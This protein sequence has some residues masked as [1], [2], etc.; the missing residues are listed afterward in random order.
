MA[1]KNIFD[2][3]DAQKAKIE[4]HLQQIVKSAFLA[5]AEYSK[6]LAENSVNKIDDVI[7]PAAIGSAEQ[8]AEELAKKIKL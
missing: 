8:Y 3:S 6:A 7:V 5:G 1:D 4:P 2:L